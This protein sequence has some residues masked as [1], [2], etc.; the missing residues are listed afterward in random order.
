MERSLRDRRVRGRK[1]KQLRESKQIQRYQRSQ[2]QHICW[3]SCSRVRPPTA[4]QRGLDSRLEQQQTRAPE[5]GCKPGPF[6]MHA[7]VRP[8]A[9]LALALGV[10]VSCTSFFGLKRDPRWVE[11]LLSQL[12]CGLTLAEIQSL[13]DREIEE[14]GLDHL[15]S[16]GIYG[17]MADIWL[18]FQDDQLVS[19]T[20]GRVDG[21]ASVRISPKKNICTGDL[22]FFVQLGW[23]VPLQG[24]TVFLDG[25]KVAEE[26]SAGLMLQVSAGEHEIRVLKDGYA[27]ITKKL[28][29]GPDDPGR[30]QLDFG[31]EED[32]L[33]DC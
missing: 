6:A 1:R 7:S 13:T 8:W 21:I 32:L 15:G 16:H 25:Q 5:E 33:P 2:Q 31:V 27:P 9:L 18:D 12:R 24:S 20:S 22:T 3:I 19:V 23:V 29:L 14:S 4:S 28:I 10:S 30:Y 26:A 11:T 17:K